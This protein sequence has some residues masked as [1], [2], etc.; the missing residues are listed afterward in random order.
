MKHNLIPQ[1]PQDAFPFIC[2]FIFAIVIANSYDL[3]ARVFL[4]PDDPVY[5]GLDPFLTA[6]ELS[7]A[8]VAI[9]AGWLGYA[10]SVYKWPHQDTKYG[11]LRFIVDIVI[12]FC[13]FGLIE[14]ADPA[15]D[16]FRGQFASW[17]CALFFL[18]LVSDI[19]KRQD[20][21][22]KTY[23]T[24]NNR[25]LKKSMVQTAFFFSASAV[26]CAVN[27]FA[28]DWWGADNDALYLMILGWA[29]S[30]LLLYRVPKWNVDGRRRRGRPQRTRPGKRSDGDG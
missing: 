10:R 12:L 16:A 7:V 13:Y 23:N 1:E 20:H 17:I 4:R 6:L 21:K 29:I 14:A 3:A 2:H 30:V 9:I 22:S 26:L 25:R 8:Y 11:V 18:Y 15:Q 5:S 24:I 28:Q 27:V 19:L